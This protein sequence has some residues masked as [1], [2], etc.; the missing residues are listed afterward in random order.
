M[1][2]VTVKGLD[3]LARELRRVDPKLGR[4]LSKANKT[5]S[6]KVVDKGRPRVTNL[7]TPG[8]T[9][10]ARGLTARAT[11]K[12]ASIALLGSNPTIR[13]STMGAASYWAWGRHRPGPGP[14]QG[15]LGQNWDPED[16]YGVGDALTETVDK[17]AVD[18]YADAYL[19]ALKGAFPE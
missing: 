18:E 9:K 7:P 19:T 13:A 4:V 2:Q 8:G 17:F 14:W 10:A 11:P 16:L 6:E 12:Q 15:W 3:E 5:V 1:A